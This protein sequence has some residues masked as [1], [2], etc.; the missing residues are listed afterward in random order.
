MKVVFCGVLV[1]A[2]ILPAYAAARCSYTDVQQKGMEVTNLQAALGR[3]QMSHVQAGRDVPAALSKRINA[4]ESELS[5]VRNAL[6]AVVE[7]QALTIG[8][9]T[10]MDPTFCRSYEQLIAKHA[11]EGYTS[12]PIKLSAATPFGCE[13]VDST[14]LWERYGVAI[15]AQTTLLQSGRINKAQTMALS[16]KFSQFGTQMSTDPAAACATFVQIESELASYEK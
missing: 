1:I 4:L 13:N 5:P 2:A 14:A 16:Q 6:T 10:A 11:P 3:E 7:P 12:A 15:Q 9:D 8:A